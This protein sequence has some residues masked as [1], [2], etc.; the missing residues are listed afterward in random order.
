MVD[1]NLSEEEFDKPVKKQPGG[2]TTAADDFSDDEKDDAVGSDESDVEVVVEDDGGADKS[3]QD[4]QARSKESRFGKRRGR[5]KTRGRDAQYV[6]NLEATVGNLQRGFDSLKGELDEVK[7]TSSRTTDANIEA[8]MNE[9]Q[10]YHDQAKSAHAQAVK[11]GD[12]VQA[13]EALDVMFEARDALSALKAAKAQPRAEGGNVKVKN[14]DV[15]VPQQKIDP[16]VMRKFDRWNSDNEWFDPRLGDQY[17]RIAFHI[18][19][20]IKA[21]GFDPRTDEY[22]DEL[23]DR[24]R[25]NKTLSNAGLFDEEDSGDDERDEDQNRGGRKMSDQPRRANNRDRDDEGD[26]TNGHRRPNPQTSRSPQNGNNGGKRKIVV[27]KAR[28]DAMREMG[29]QPGT[30]EWTTMAKKYAGWDKQHA[31][32]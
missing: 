16:T 14:D 4:V 27:S 22:W 26:R 8:Q 23:N 32:A 1:D 21:E 31:N 17:S 25:D 11:D 19:N 24:L 3:D 13:A 30:K 7:Q 12:G 9:A 20:A 2:E 5:F 29:L 18:D 15:K 28:A 6:R 10:R